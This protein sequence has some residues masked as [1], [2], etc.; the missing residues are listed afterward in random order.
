M[1]HIH[2]LKKKFSMENLFTLLSARSSECTTYSS[3][4]EQLEKSFVQSRE[5][6][7]QFIDLVRQLKLMSFAS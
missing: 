7:K 3:S 4:N 6:K 2:S 1:I 5:R